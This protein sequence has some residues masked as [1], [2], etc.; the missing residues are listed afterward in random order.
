MGHYQNIVESKKLILVNT[1]YG[2]KFIVIDSITMI[3]AHN[4]CSI[5]Y[6]L[7]SKQIEVNH[8][9]K[10]L[11]LKLRRHYFFR[12]NRSTLINC[13]HVKFFSSKSIIMNCNNNVMISGIN[14]KKFL[15]F[16]SNYLER[17]CYNP[18]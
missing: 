13:I 8:L 5:I 18:N 15:E 7:D 3:K 10:I 16:Y 17:I 11:A 4:K 1:R 12:C 9:L 14:Y 6:T 2:K